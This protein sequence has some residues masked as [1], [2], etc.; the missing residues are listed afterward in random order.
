MCMSQ[1]KKAGQKH[2]I[3]IANRSFEDVA[4]FKCLGPS[5]AD[6]K[7]YERRDSEQTKFGECLLP[8]GPE[9]FVVPPAV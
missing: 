5:L 8:F 7:L 2:S 4:Q 9:S 1:C 3:K 6:Q